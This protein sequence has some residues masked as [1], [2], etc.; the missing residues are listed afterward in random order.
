MTNTIQKTINDF[1]KEHGHNKYKKVNSK[2]IK[3]KKVCKHFKDGK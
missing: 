3:N 1:Y 2:C